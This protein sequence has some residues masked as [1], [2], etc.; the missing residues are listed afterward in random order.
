M[1]SKW[2]KQR[3]SVNMTVAIKCKAKHKQEICK[4]GEGT[5]MKL[6]ITTGKYLPV[7]PTDGCVTA[8]TITITAAAIR[9]MLLIFALN[10]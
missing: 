8:S 1:L 5:R 9:Y 6:N 7:W 4:V 2:G 10:V 3:R